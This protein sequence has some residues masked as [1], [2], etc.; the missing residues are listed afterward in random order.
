VIAR[1]ALAACAASLAACAARVPPRPAGPP[2]PDPSAIEAFVAATRSCAGVRTLTA[3]LRLSGRAGAE[4]IRGTLQTGLAAPAAIRV[5]AVAPFGQPFFILGGRD[6]RATLLLPRDNQVLPD[7]PVPELLDRLTGL[8]IAA[9]AVRVIITGCLAERPDPVD[10]RRWADG[11]QA[12]SLANPSAAS[13]ITAYLRTVDGA[14]VV[15]A[16]DH[17]DWRVDY[18]DHVN[19]FPRR[20]RLRSASG[21]AVDLTATV[22]QLSTNVPIPERAFAVDAPPSA[23]ILSIDDLRRVTPL[24]E[25]T[26]SKFEVQSERRSLEVVEFGPFAARRAYMADVALRSGPGDHHSNLTTTH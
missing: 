1:L 14:P 26:S 5:E 20:V 8:R 18:A 21:D 15:V 25:G 11:W 12:V 13:P 4:R 3:E 23:A 10:G 22:G 19:G 17:G 7:A 24:R 9:D 2:A 6:N 16:A